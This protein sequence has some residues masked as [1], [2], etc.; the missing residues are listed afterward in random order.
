MQHSHYLRKGKVRLM[1]ATKREAEEWRDAATLM[2]KGLMIENMF[3]HPPSTRARSAFSPP[4]RSREPHVAKVNDYLVAGIGSPFIFLVL[5]RLALL[6]PL[7]FLPLGTPL[8]STSSLSYLDV[9]LT[10][11]SLSKLKFYSISTV[12]TFF[13]KFLPQ[14]GVFVHLCTSSSP[15]TIPFLHVLNITR[16]V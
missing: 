16:P 6:Y 13:P 10:P 14:R 8:D 9:I 1:S 12:R 5:F 2:Q 15:D 4:G 7:S 11:S 3:Y